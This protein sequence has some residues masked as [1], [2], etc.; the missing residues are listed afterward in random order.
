MA[1]NRARVVGIILI[2]AAGLTLFQL[3]RHGLSRFMSQQKPLLAPATSVVDKQYNFHLVT[4]G[5]WRSAQPGRA[6]LQRMKS[7][8]L[9]TIVNMRT[10]PYIDQWESKLAKK[11]NIRY[12]PF[13]IDL[14]QPPNPAVI[15]QILSVI[16]DPANQPV[17]IHCAGGKDRTGMM[18]AI[19]RLEV[20]HMKFEDVRKEMLMCGYDEKRYPYLIETV[21]AWSQGRQS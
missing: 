4:P 2:L 15:R 21:R 17:L 8:G 1:K 19:Y 13:P 12:Y 5:L 7:Y 18:T 9:K 11:L 16:C 6:S 20:E 3:T 14:R 10:E